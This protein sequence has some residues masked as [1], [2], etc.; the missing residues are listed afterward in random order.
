M[1]VTNR[2]YADLLLQIDALTSDSATTTESTRI[3][4]LINLARTRAKVAT[5]YWERW[6]VVD[7][8]RRV[9]RGFVQVNED[10]YNVYG[11]GTDAVNGLYEVNGTANG[12]ARYSQ[13]ADDGT[14]VLWDIE[15]DGSANWEILVGAGNTDLTENTVYYTVVNTDS[16]P[17]ES[18]WTIDNGVRE[19]PLLKPTSSIET[20]LYWTKQS[21][22]RTAYRTYEFSS[23]TYGLK[24]W[25]NSSESGIIYVTYTK[26]DTQKIG[27]GTNGTTTVVPE[28]WFDYISLYVAYTYQASQRQS[29]DNPGYTIA[30]REV[31]QALWD[32]RM[33]LETQ[34]T[35]RLVKDNVQSRIAYSNML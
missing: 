18:G 28:E 25:G 30:L 16:L 12:N 35:P 19:S 33:R 26:K 31:N 27:D 29:N 1:P 11:A 14:T 20:A 34:G 24:P 4:N 3:N 5:D 23:D 15:Y 10:S 6:L 9:S 13:Y 8:P 32:Q 7:E 21:N 17:P 2:T 22:S